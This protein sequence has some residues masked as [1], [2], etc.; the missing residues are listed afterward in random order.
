MWQ[1]SS[2]VPHVRKIIKKEH[3]CIV[4]Q[5]LGI[6]S[7]NMSKLTSKNMPLLKFISRCVYK[8][9]FGYK[10]LSQNKRPCLLAFMEIIA[11]I[12][13]MW[14]GFAFFNFSSIQTYN[15]W[16]FIS[17]VHVCNALSLNLHWIGSH[18]Q[19]KIWHWRNKI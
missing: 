11:Y 10:Y 2:I 1:F 18:L 13:V 6:I 12:D 9:I 4:V 8:V 15:V 17:H 16:A 5:I 19:L 3:H 14:L 7:Q